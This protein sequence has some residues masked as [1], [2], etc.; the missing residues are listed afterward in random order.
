MSEPMDGEAEVGTGAHVRRRA[1]RGS[2]SSREG[3]WA[4]RGGEKPDY[5]GIQSVARALRILEQFD[6][7]RRS[8]SVNELAILTGLSRSTV[9][10][11]CDTLHELGYLDE[12]EQRRYRP[13][14]R[15]ALLARAALAS[16]DL[17]ELALP[18]L[19]RLRD[20]TGE[21]V[22]MAVLDGTEVVYIARLLSEHLIT[23]RLYVGSRLPAYACSLGR[24]ILAYLPPEEAEA[25]IRR[26]QFDA[27]TDHTVSSPRV[28][29]S[30]L[31]RV[32]GQGFAVN[33][34]GIAVGLRGVAAPVLLYGIRPV[35]SINISIPH[36]LV[37]D[38]HIKEVLAPLV[39][40][41]AHDIAKFVELTTGTNGRSR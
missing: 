14:L 3:Q 8:A 38:D 6:E 7:K 16:R 33:D 26:T 12:L 9:Y 29:R 21:T 2:S 1:G 20:E 4:P 24:A 31:E 23:L 11:F 39:V 37:T 5:G 18:Y 28:L 41:A 15:A 13:G 27:L 34:Q 30:E 19:R 32:R 40:Q 36:P 17:P 35:A 25:I 10:R 22:N